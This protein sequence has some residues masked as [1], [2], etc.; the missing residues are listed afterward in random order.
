MATQKQ[1]DKALDKLY[2]A[3]GDLVELKGGKIVV[4]G[5]VDIIKCPDER[6][7][8]LGIRCTGKLPDPMSP[9]AAD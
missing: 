9:R 1:I 3:A 6:N 4:V 5:G 2:K 8:I 7:W